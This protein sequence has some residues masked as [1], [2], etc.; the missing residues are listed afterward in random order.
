MAN[1]LDKNATASG[2][3][4]FSKMNRLAIKHQALNLG[5]GFPDYPAP[6]FLKQ[7][8]THAIEQDVNQYTSARGDLTLR[9]AIA[10][11]IERRYGLSY[12]PDSDITI[13]QGATEA[14]S[15]S[16]LSLVAP[17]DEVILFEPA[18]STYL[19][20]IEKAGGIVKAYPLLP[21]DW[22]IDFQKLKSLFSAKTKVMLLNTPHNPTGKVMTDAELSQ[23]AQLCQQY[24]VSVISDEVYENFVFD[25]HQHTCF[26]CYPGMYERTIVVSNLG[27]TFE[28]TG[29]KIGWTIA[30][31]TLTEGIL[32]VRQYMTGSGAAPLQAAA[33]TAMQSTQTFY[34]ELVHRYQHKRDLFYQALLKTGLQPILPQGGCFM[35]ADFSNLAFGNDLE[36]CHYLITEIGLA[37]I[38]ASSLYH[39]LP[40]G[41]KLLR[42]AFCKK[43][44]TL[45][46]AEKR[47]LQIK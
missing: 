32:Q 45:L 16:I 14:V 28:V 29:W 22:H 1:A 44:E 17:G 13:T 43:T 10:A 3:T 34:D 33:T 15:A 26:S 2:D 12:N 8:A 46:E 31:A 7:A 21:P 39:R 6:T 24:D 47:L 37:A 38:P 35:M 27:K 36:F 30:P 41:V 18:Y 4:I 19:P 40:E 11:R 9:Q 23:L 5:H 42:F 25:N 20:A